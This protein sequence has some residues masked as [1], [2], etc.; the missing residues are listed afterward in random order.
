MS[1]TV[2]FK[3]GF[4]TLLENTKYLNRFK[5]P[6]FFKVIQK[7]VTFVGLRVGSKNPTNV[8]ISIMKLEQTY[9]VYYWKLLRDRENFIQTLREVH[10]SNYW[11]LEVLAWKKSVILVSFEKNE[12][13]NKHNGHCAT[14]GNITKAKQRLPREVNIRFQKGNWLCKRTLN[15]VLKFG[16]LNAYRKHVKNT[17]FVRYPTGKFSPKCSFDERTTCTF[18]KNKHRSIWW[19][20][21][22]TIICLKKTELTFMAATNYLNQER[23]SHSWKDFSI[24]TQLFTN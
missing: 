6:N 8:F 1:L 17:V 5:N 14:S 7:Q 18:Y 20:S 13:I 2:Y 21:C 19:T 10:C 12:S 15:H 4:L 9:C 11:K 22:I 24:S 3:K 23:I 16:S